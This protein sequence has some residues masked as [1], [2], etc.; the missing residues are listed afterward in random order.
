MQHHV[1]LLVNRTF[2]TKMRFIFNIQTCTVPADSKT[3]DQFV[4]EGLSLGD[5]TETTGGNL[6]GIQLQIQDNIV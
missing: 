4:T 5:G 1:S 2:K 3:S 6:L